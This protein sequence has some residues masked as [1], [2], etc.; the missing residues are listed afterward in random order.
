MVW[1]GLGLELEEVID[2]EVRNPHF[3]HKPRSTK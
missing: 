2:L 1:R 3:H